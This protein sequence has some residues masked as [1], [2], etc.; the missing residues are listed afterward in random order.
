VELLNQPFD[1]FKMRVIVQFRARKLTGQTRVLYNRGLRVRG[2]SHSLNY[3]AGLS[4]PATESNAF[5]NHS[6]LRKESAL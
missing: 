3:E 5:R 1:I 2:L 4:L 6:D